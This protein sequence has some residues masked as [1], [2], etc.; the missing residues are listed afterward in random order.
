MSWLF[1]KTKTPD[2]TNIIRHAKVDR[3][4]GFTKSTEGFSETRESAYERVLGKAIDVSHE[5]V[6]QIPHIDVYRY[7]L[8]IADRPICVLVT[9][10]MSDL[11]MTMPPHAED[12]PQ[13]A[14]LIF[15]C[16]ESRPEYIDT[17]RW[18][19]H[20]PHDAGSWLGPGHT[21]P[22]GNPPAPFWGSNDLNTIFF[23]SP[24]VSTHQ[25]LPEELTLGGDRVHFLWVVPLTTAECNYKLK[26]GFGAMMQ[27]F[28]KN[29][30]PLSF[31]PARKSYV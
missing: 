29:K 19:A 8:T 7:Q 6:P 10:G 15:Y 3:Q 2:G 28:G 13:R 11:P 26:N 30:H 17:L 12:I 23:L 20:F 21:V 4:V 16:E 25:K 18:L 22:N 1:G 27:L 5:L 24:I 31:D 9:G 14:E